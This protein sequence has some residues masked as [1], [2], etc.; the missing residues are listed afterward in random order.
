MGVMRSVLLKA[1]QSRTLRERAPRYWFVRRT[2]ARFMPGENVQDALAAALTLEAAGLGTV[3]TQLGENITDAREATSVTQHY[4]GVL[5][6]VRALGL[7]TEIS[8]KLTQLGLDLAADLCYDNLARILERADR[9]STV[10]IDMEASEYADRTIDIFRRARAAYPNV[11]VCLQAYLLRTAEDLRSLLPLGPAIRL[12]KGA[13]QEPPERAFP[14]K[15]NVDENYFALAQQLLSREAQAAGVR[16]AMATHDRHLIRRIEQFAAANGVG[17]SSFEFQM[18]YGI[19]REEQQRLVREGWRAA[20]LI[21][22]GSYWYPWFMRRLAE[23]PA[24][25]LFVLRNLAS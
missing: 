17:K 9:S 1:A 10:W 3:F 7:R 22:Y 15:K 2:V 14:K 20:V 18:L 4:L 24:N 8:V 25:L 21:A 11:G 13:Y 6:Q 12:V 23:R 5:D 16:A 19:Q